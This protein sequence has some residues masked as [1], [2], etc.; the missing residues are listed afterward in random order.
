MIGV[1]E[2]ETTMESFGVV[3]FTAMMLSLELLEIYLLIL[4]VRGLKVVAPGRKHIWVDYPS[5][6]SN[7]CLS[8][9]LAAG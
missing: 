5:R 1:L 7:G 6:F 4:P 3:L 9:S 2:Y 8:W